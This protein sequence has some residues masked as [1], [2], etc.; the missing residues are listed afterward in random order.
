MIAD[1]KEHRV[2]ITDPSY[3]QY[4]EIN[5]RLHTWSPDERK[6][7]FT[8]SVTTGCG[9]T[10][11]PCPEV[12]V[13]EGLPEGFLL[14]DL[15]AGTVQHLASLSTK[16]HY[17]FEGWLDNDTLVFERDNVVYEYTL[18]D[19]AI[20]PSSRF[21]TPFAKINFFS[22]IGTAVDGTYLYV[23]GQGQNSGTP[24]ELVAR[25]DGRDQVIV[26]YP[27]AKLQSRD[28]SISD[29]GR[30]VSWTYQDTGVTRTYDLLE[31]IEVSEGLGT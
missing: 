29:D 14:A 6:L 9:M 8:L 21:G 23:R 18:G 7:L 25:K 22:F 15:D 20:T 4:P 1:T 3:A 16:T 5:T 31:Q 2:A 28:I 10:A 13:P 24:L 17:Y 26:S 12:E 27:W 30:F 11:D 19:L